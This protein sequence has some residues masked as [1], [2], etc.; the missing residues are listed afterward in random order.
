MRK[1]FLISTLLLSGLTTLYPQEIIRLT[2]DD[3]LMLARQQSLQAFLNQ[4][5]FMIDYWNYRNY[6]AYM[7]PSVPF[8]L[9]SGNPG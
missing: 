1:Y 6:R 2:L 3:A 5:Y 9:I 7:L 4:H 8:P